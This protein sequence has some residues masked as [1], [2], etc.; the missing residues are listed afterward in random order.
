MKMIKTATCKRCGSNSV[1]WVKSAKTGKFYLAFAV[2]GGYRSDGC[3]YPQ[4]LHKCDDALRGGFAACKLCG[5]HHYSAFGLSDAA[6]C[7]RH[8]AR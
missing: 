6:E 7:E 5:Q 1:A 4:T 3:V 8:A 2:Q